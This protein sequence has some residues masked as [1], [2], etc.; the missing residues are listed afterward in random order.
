MKPSGTLNPGAIQIVPV[1]KSAQG[2]T[3]LL[4]GAPIGAGYILHWRVTIVTTS[5][6]IQIDAP[7]NIYLQLPR[8]GVLDVVFANPRSSVDYGFTEL[9]V[10]NLIDVFNLTPIQI[11]VTNKSVS[12][13]TVAFT[14]HPPTDNYFL[15][16]RTP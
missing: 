13:F 6:I 2:F 16:I 9:T 10:E 8:D 15:R 5:S 1:T 14:P 3:V 12:G 7:E 4:A 11:L